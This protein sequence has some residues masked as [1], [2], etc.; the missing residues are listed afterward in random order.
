MN[1]YLKIFPCAVVNR[2]MIKAF[3]IQV[4]FYE[5]HLFWIVFPVKRLDILFIQ[6][7]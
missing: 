2:F 7:H 5:A 3:K 1:M 4:N 6:F